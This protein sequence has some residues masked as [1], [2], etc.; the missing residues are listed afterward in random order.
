MYNL[1][2]QA[3]KETKNS[4][5]TTEGGQEDNWVLTSDEAATDGL[6]EEVPSKLRSESQE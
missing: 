1:P 6:S 3:N 4:M 2:S 5:L